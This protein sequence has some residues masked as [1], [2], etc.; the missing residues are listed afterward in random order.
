MNNNRLHY[1]LHA[2]VNKE[3]TW[4]EEDELMRLVSD[5]ANEAS[6][7]GILDGLYDNNPAKLRLPSAESKEI[8]FEIFKHAPAEKKTIPLLSAHKWRYI[9]AAAA[10]LLLAVTFSFSLLRNIFNDNKMADIRSVE[11]TEDVKPGRNVAFL[12]L[13]NDSVIPLD[14]V[15]LGS[16]IRQRCAQIVKSSE[17][18]L[19]YHED[20]LA[21]DDSMPLEYHTLATPRGGQ[22]KLTLPDGSRVWLNAESSLRFPSAFAS[23]ERRVE[24]KGEAYFEIA[25]QPG[26]PFIVSLADHPGFPEGIEIEVLGT[27][28]NVM[29][30]GDEPMIATTLVEGSVRIGRLKVADGQATLRPGQQAVMMSGGK[31]EISEVDLFEATAWKDGY[32]VF[33]DEDIECIMRKLARWYNVDVEYASALTYR[34]FSGMISRYENISRALEKFELT[35]AISFD[36]KDNRI[37]VKP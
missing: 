29:A 24:I 7:M 33:S 35:G 36:V 20:M 21:S 16:V 22:F 26:R 34:E 5:P 19:I 12:T 37:I 1:L 10:V 31:P 3:C 25:H 18:E 9:A 17:G 32:F 4:A 15:E 14:H 6:I 2:Y 30:Y 28:F 27:H 13:D 23:Q 8:L 11:Y